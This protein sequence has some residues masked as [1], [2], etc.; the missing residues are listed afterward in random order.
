MT[1]FF[2]SDTH[3]R[4]ENIIKYCSRPFENVEHMDAEIIKRWNAV[5]HPSD[6][7]YHLGDLCM[8]D[9]EN[10]K[11]IL[12]HLNG[13]ITVLAAPWHHDKRWATKA[14]TQTIYSNSGYAVLVASVMMTIS[15]LGYPPIALCHYPI[16]DWEQKH[17]GSWHLHGHSHG[18]YQSDGLCL[19]VGVDSWG[20]APVRL[21][22]LDH[23]M[24]DRR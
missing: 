18:G 17:H 12:R 19:D 23:A 9:Y 10:A 11:E 4:H 13:V 22:V 15:I 8:G 14:R 20:F 21:S 24:H 6:T 5:V 1:T 16:A 3:F 7:I 2:T